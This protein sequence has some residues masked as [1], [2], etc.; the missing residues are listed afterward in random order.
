[1]TQ[2]SV[3]DTSALTK[4]RGA[5]GQM[6]GR[7]LDPQALADVQALLGD[8]PRRRDLLIEFL[9]RIQ[10]R[11]GYI[12]AAHI[13]ALAQEMKLAMTEVYEVATFYH[14]FDVVKEG[15]DAAAGGAP[16]ASAKRCRARWPGADALRAGAANAP[17][18]ATCASSARR[19]SAAA[20]TRR[21]PSSAAIRSTTRRSTP[22]SPRSRKTPSRRDAPLHRLRRAIARQAATRTLRACA[23]GERARRRRHRRNG[24]FRTAR[25]SAA[26]A[27][28]PAASG[29]S[30]AP[31]PRRG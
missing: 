20:S 6:K 21:S 5:R 2:K 1:M 18:A 25:A 8:A 28:P 17:A 13:V 15:D 12:S 3:V 23:N 29:A 30:C 16:C 11:Y 24:E 7:T 27:F 14:H 22:S 4:R 26:P 9:H 31:S 19:A 10:D